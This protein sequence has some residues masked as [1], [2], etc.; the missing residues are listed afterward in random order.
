MIQVRRFAPQTSARPKNEQKDKAKP[1]RRADKGVA[2]EPL[3]ARHLSRSAA[4]FGSLPH[5]LYS[6]YFFGVIAC[7]AVRFFVLHK[8]RFDWVKRIQTWYDATKRI[9]NVYSAH[10]YD[11]TVLMRYVICF[12]ARMLSEIK[13]NQFDVKLKQV[14]WTM[15][16]LR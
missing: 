4:C 7:L 16:V 15:S 2:A 10:V 1:K 11:Y 12:Y 6:L 14:H 13:L 3:G 8:K 5:C 9:V